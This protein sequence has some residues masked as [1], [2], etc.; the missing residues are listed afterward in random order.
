MADL[1]LYCVKKT[2]NCDSNV[3][4]FSLLKR[5]QVF[6]RCWLWDTSVNERYIN[7]FY[8]IHQ[9]QTFSS[10]NRKY[11]CEA[12]LTMLINCCSDSELRSSLCEK[13]QMQLQ[14]CATGLSIAKQLQ[15]QHHWAP[16]T[17]FLGAVT[18]RAG[19]AI[20]I[21]LFLSCF[22]NVKVVVHGILPH[23]RFQ[24]IIEIDGHSNYA[25]LIKQNIQ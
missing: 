23:D 4:I 6:C 2:L 16:T 15:S 21:W 22:G 11:S 14:C 25:I 18:E 5:H 12:W 1:L 8:F 7:L 3:C 9:N 10:R 13:V 19:E 20:S 24:A 17:G